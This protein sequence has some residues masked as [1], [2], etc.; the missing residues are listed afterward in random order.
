MRSRAHRRE[1]KPGRSP[2]R[3]WSRWI[4]RSPSCTSTAKLILDE[5]ERQR[6]GLPRAVPRAGDNELVVVAGWPS[7]RRPSGAILTKLP[8]IY[9][10]AA[11]TGRTEEDLLS[12]LKAVHGLTRSS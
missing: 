12:D 5:I 3:F 6:L 1:A 8:W 11:M 7:R 2:R 4:R 9:I 10:P